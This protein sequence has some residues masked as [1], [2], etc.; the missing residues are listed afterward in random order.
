MSTAGVNLLENAS[1]T[2]D[3]KYFEGGRAA[4]MVSGTLPTTF[5]LQF[6]DAANNAVAVDTITAVGDTSYDLPTGWYRMSVSGGSP[7]GL[8][9]ALVRTRN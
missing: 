7:A 1:A 8:Y 4:L 9:A 3:W 5:I 2:G 6:R